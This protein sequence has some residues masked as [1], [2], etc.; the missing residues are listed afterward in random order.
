[1]HKLETVFYIFLQRKLTLIFF[2]FYYHKNRKTFSIRNT[3]KTYMVYSLFCQRSILKPKNDQTNVYVSVNTECF[4]LLDSRAVYNCSYSQ[5]WYIFFLSRKSWQP[6]VLFVPSC[7]NV[8]ALEQA[9]VNISQF[10]MHC[11]LWTV[12]LNCIFFL[13][14]PL[15]L[16]L[17][18]YEWAQMFTKWEVLLLTHF[19]NRNNTFLLQRLLHS[20]NL[21]PGN[22]AMCL[23]AP[24]F[25]HE[26]LAHL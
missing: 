15:V 11:R 18:I 2:K 17:Q 14:S 7:N 6:F 26:L 4:S 24:L 12:K 25:Y 19:Y 21:L 16:K 20:E 5:F 13:K 1:M 22:K 3:K 8:L 10:Y 23:N 9:S